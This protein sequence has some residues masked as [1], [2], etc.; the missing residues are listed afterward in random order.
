MVSS[1]KHTVGIYEL[2]IYGHANHVQYLHWLEEGRERL[3]RQK[4][5]S[6]IS[7]GEA[8]RR[9]VIANVGLDFKAPLR[10]GEEISVET[11]IEKVGRTSVRFGQ[12]I[13]GAV[14]GLALEG[15]VTM[16]FVDSAGKP[17]EVPESFKKAFC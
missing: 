12:R 7:F 17:A 1:F 4:G 8:G 15:S 10:A 14:A 2:D 3:M 13:S 6:F 11:S 5:M 16:V 9:L